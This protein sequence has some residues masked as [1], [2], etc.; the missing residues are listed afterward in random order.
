MNFTCTV[1]I[2]L[3]QKKVVELFKDSDN[4]KEWQDGFQSTELISGKLKEVRAKSLLKFKNGKRLMELQ[5]T[6]LVSD[7]PSEFTGEF[8]HIHMSNT[9]Q[10]LFTEVDEN[11]TRWTANIEYTKL[12]SLLIKI[13]VKFFPNMFKKQT[14]KWL[15]QFKVF[16]ER[17]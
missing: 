4:N 15:D 2:D 3:S 5:E 9:M 11:T 10:N 12:N 17:K 13:I 1:D 7:L 8:V 14:Q 16:A 6:V